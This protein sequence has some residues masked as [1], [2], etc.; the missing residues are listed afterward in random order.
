MTR[1][2]HDSVTQMEQLADLDPR[3]WL[4]AVLTYHRYE[5]DRELEGMSG[6]RTRVW[7]RIKNRIDTPNPDGR[8]TSGAAAPSDR[9]GSEPSPVVPRRHGR[10]ASFVE[11]SRLPDVLATPSPTAGADRRELEPIGPMGD[12]QLARLMCALDRFA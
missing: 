1:T 7:N 9:S 5:F 8:A 4:R 10:T 2:G 6:P 3:I 11:P 12:H